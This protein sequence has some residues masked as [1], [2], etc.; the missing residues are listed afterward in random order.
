MLLDSLASKA[1][2]PSLSPQHWDYR[3]VILC[4]IFY[5][6]AGGLNTY[7]LA[8]MGSTLQTEPSS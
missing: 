5:M 4:L 3:P 1:L 2:L 8:C 7:P 6:G